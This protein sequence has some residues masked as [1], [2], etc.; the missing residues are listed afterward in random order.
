[1]NSALSHRVG[2]VMLTD[3]IQALSSS[4]KVAWLHSLDKAASFQNLQGSPLELLLKAEG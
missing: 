4:Q 3:T 1:M 2:A